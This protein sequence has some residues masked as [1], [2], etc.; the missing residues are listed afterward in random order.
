MNKNKILL[1]SLLGILT[2][3]CYAQ[4]N[5]F[6]FGIKAA[7]NFAW[8][9]PDT[10]GYENDGSVIGFSTG[11]VTEIAFTDNYGFK[12]GLN[13]DYLNG[14]LKFPFV[15]DSDTGTMS[16]KYNLRYLELPLTIKMRTNKFGDM[17]YFGEIGVGTA[18]NVRAK[19]KDD[20][21]NELTGNSLQSEKDISDEITLM[22]E[23]VIMGAG[24]EYFIDESTSLF[25]ELTF[26]AGLTNI[27]KGNNT[28]YPD[29]EQKGKLYNLQLSIGVL[30]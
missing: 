28:L 10:E 25:L 2:I 17:A 18:F 15:S 13:F 20:F 30:F 9:A 24:A 3:Q 1:I 5:S 14:K 7:P 23:S 27:L 11:F 22:K 29:L 8:I 21:Q 12:T 19:S 16:R 6:R 26:N 4:D